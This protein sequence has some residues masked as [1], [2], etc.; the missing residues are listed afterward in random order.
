MRFT[1][2]V[3]DMDLVLLKGNKYCRSHL[4]EVSVRFTKRA[5][6]KALA[7]LLLIVLS[8]KLRV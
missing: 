5:R 8:A 7:P 6:L 1:D 3:S 4:R 2:I